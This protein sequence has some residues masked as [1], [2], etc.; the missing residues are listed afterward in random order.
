MGVYI[1][2]AHFECHVT[3]M[4]GK[5]PIKWRQRPDMTFAVD[6]DVKHQLKKKKKQKKT[7]IISDK[8]FKVKG[9]G[10]VM[11][12]SYV[13]IF[14]QRLDPNNCYPRNTCRSLSR[15]SSIHRTAMTSCIEQINIYMYTNVLNNGGQ[16]DVFHHTYHIASRVI[17]YFLEGGHSA[18]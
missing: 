15:A 5:S 17:N 2:E 14:I 9:V 6:W 18:A 16:C 3:L 11:D 4:L 13:H 8:T 10:S 1:Y 12:Y 7:F